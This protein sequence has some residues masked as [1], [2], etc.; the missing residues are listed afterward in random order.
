MPAIFRAC[1]SLSRIAT[2]RSTVP[3]ISRSPASHRLTVRPLSTPT[4]FAKPSA[5]RPSSRRACFNSSGVMSGI[6]SGDKLACVVY[7]DAIG[8]A[9]AEICSH[10]FRDLGIRTSVDQLMGESAQLGNH[11]VGEDHFD[12]SISGGH[13]RPV[14]EIEYRSIGPMRQAIKCSVPKYFSALSERAA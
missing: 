14:D 4:A 8:L 3:G 6:T 7:S 12:F 9:G 10:R 1:G 13:Q 5:E 11:A 2:S